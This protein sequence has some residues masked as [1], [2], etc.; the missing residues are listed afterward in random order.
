MCISNQDGEKITEV[1]M[2]SVCNSA[3]TEVHGFVTK[4]FASCIFSFSNVM[5]ISYF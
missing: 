1:G 5:L 4:L 3:E 2:I